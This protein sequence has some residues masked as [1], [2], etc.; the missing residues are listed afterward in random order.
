MAMPLCFEMQNKASLRHMLCKIKH[1]WLWK[2]KCIWRCFGLIVSCRKTMS[3]CKSFNQLIN[4]S[5]CSLE[6]TPY[7]KLVGCWRFTKGSL[8]DSVFSSECLH[9]L[10]AEPHG[11]IQQSKNFMLDFQDCCVSRIATA[12]VIFTY[13]SPLLSAGWGFK[14][15]H[16]PNKMMGGCFQAPGHPFIW[17]IDE[18]GHQE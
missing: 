14:S 3:A 11:L 10:Q 5:L 16:S 18:T 6:L 7:D 9:L 1:V 17:R 15:L 2:G 8:E 13:M 4:L 12:L